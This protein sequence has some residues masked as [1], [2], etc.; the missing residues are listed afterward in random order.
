MKKK[1][2]LTSC[3]SLDFDLDILPAFLEHYISMGIKP[4]NVIL[5]LNVFREE[6]REKLELSYAIL[7][8]FE[9][10]LDKQV[11]WSSEYES[12][13]KWKLVDEQISKYAPNDGSAWIIHPDADE[14]HRIDNI[15]R[16]LEFLEE[17]DFNALQGILIDRVTHDGKVPGKKIYT[18]YA[19]L[20]ASFP[21][22]LY[23][24]DLLGIAGVKLMIYRSD[25]RANNG[26]GQIHP[27]MRDIVRYP[28]GSHSLHEDEEFRSTV[29]NFVDN[30][31]PMIVDQSFLNH[32]CCATNCGIVDHYK[33]HGTVIDKL[34]QRIRTYARL[35]R[36]QVV[37]SIR[38]MEH[39]NKNES[40][41]FLK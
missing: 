34:A 10:D 37:Q 16:T 22:E 38:F 18:D 32:L 35:Q 21:T 11:I 25:L 24:A 6:S 4:E 5:V 36:P 29:P 41:R 12:E 14:F 39:Y 40:I 28:Y 9:V 15:A 13:T 23:L 3:I 20:D 33:W 27:S 8:H 19:S 26:S 31:T 7:K 2:Y 1:A 17:N 30:D